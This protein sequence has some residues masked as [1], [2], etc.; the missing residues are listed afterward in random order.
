[1]GPARVEPRCA[2]TPWRRFAPARPRAG[3]RLRLRGRDQRR[4]VHPDGREE[5][6]LAL[7]EVTGDWA[8]ATRSV[9]A[10]SGLRVRAGDGRVACNDASR[11]GGGAFRTCHSRAGRR[12]PWPMNSCRW[13]RCTSCRQ[14]CSQQRSAVTRS[15]PASRAAGRRGGHARRR[16]D[17]PAR[18]RGRADAGRSSPAEHSSSVP[19]CSSTRSANACSSLPARTPA[20]ARRPPVAGAVLAGSGSRGS[21]AQAEARIRATLSRGTVGR[22]MTEQRGLLMAG[23]GAAA[24]AGPAA[25]RRG[26]GAIAERRRARAEVRASHCHV[27]SPR[28]ERPCRAVRLLSGPDQAGCRVGPVD[29][30]DDDGLWSTSRP[31]RRALRRREPVRRVTTSSWNRCALPV[32]A[33]RST[34]A[35]TN[36]AESALARAAE[37]QST[38]RGRR[39]G[40]RGHEV[41]HGRATG[42]APAHRRRG[43][44]TGPRKPGRAPGRCRHDTGHAGRRRHRRVHVPVRRSDRGHGS[45]L[46]LS[47]A[48]EA[49]LKPWRPATSPLIPSRAP[50]SCTGRSR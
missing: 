8:A 30:L 11:A 47:T 31:R 3:D 12:W 20:S 27:R 46:L 41:V 39:A 35:V 21:H 43:G 49:A 22:V 29:P 4:R 33:G 36:D 7:G 17:P 25:R 19:L 2:T 5:R 48:R 6:F 32:S 38:V 24:G 16:T 26:A 10:G 13:R 40:R 45:W 44:S 50:T 9:S 37:P 28:D 18:S 34:V 1:M 15:P 23:G 14:W 42:A